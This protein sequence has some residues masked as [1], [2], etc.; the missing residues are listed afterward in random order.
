MRFAILAVAVAGGL[1]GA[2]LLPAAVRVDADA[3]WRAVSQGLRRSPH[4][5]VLVAPAD[6]LV[7]FHDVRGGI[8]SVE[9][10]VS[11]RAA[12]GSTRVEVRRGE[13]MFLQME[14]G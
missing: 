13:P 12:G 6:G 4:P 11:A 8:A 5:G 1:A 2:L 14:L 10:R 9:L 7:H 3:D